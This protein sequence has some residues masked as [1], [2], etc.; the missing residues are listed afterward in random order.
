MGDQEMPEVTVTI[1]LTCVMLQAGRWC[2]TVLKLYYFNR[3][4][5]SKVYYL[6]AYTTI[7]F[8]IL[9]VYLLILLYTHTFILLFYML[10]N[11]KFQQKTK[12][13]TLQYN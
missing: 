13:K 9:L 6:Y 12:F 5:C 10:M 8:G 7:C 11:E 4:I 3:T 2:H 1:I